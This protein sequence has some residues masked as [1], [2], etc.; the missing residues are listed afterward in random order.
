MDISFE[1]LS[2][3]FRPSYAEVAPSG[4]LRIDLRIDEAALR[5]GLT[6][7]LR[8]WA[9]QWQARGVTVHRSTEEDL[10]LLS[11]SLAIPPSTRGMGCC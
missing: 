2:C 6:K 3:G 1:L 10:G 7:R 11:D 5:H 9:N 8:T 4:S